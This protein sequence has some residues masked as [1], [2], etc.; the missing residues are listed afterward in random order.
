[1]SEYLSDQQKLLAYNTARFRA[2]LEEAVIPG[3]VGHEA[4][5]D[6]VTIRRTEM[7]I[8]RLR[9]R[10]QRQ[11]SDNGKEVPALM[12]LE[13]ADKQISKSDLDKFISKKTKESKSYKKAYSTINEIHLFYINS[14][15]TLTSHMGRMLNIA[16]RIAEP[17]V[18]PRPTV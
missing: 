7:D 2:L 6:F 13:I 12:K 15:R 17:Y 18:S 5:I 11:F 8:Y 1:M 14:D 10:C 3:S 9:K 16:A 4:L